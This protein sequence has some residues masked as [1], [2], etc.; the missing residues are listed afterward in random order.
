[1]DINCTENDFS[2]FFYGNISLEELACSYSVMMCHKLWN[3]FKSQPDSLATH[4]IVKLCHQS[5]E[6]YDNKFYEMS[7]DHTT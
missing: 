6:I 2:L 7:N 4:P 1:M 3:S 5:T